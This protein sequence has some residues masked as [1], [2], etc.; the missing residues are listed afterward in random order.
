MFSRFFLVIDKKYKKHWTMKNCW[1]EFNLFV[2]P[3]FTI[4]TALYAKNYKKKACNK[5][6]KYGD[7]NMKRSEAEL[8]TC[9]RC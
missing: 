1:V 6:S 2:A 5:E 9:C 3:V 4:I 7:R 8:E